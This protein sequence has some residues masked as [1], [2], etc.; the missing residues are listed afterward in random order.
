[1]ES[2]AEAQLLTCD[3]V[4]DA[5][6]SGFKTDKGGMADPLPKLVGV[7]RQGGFRYRGTLAKPTLLVLTSNLAEPDWPDELDAPT[8]RFVYYGDNRHPGLQLHDTQRFGNQLLIKLFDM[9]HSEERA[10]IPPVLIFTSEGPG[11]SYRFRGLAVPG[12]PTMPATEDLV[13][14]WKTAGNRRFQNYRAVF[15]ILDV[16]VL[17]RRWIESIKSGGNDMASAPSAWRSWIES[18]AIKPLEAP[19]TQLIRTKEEQLPSSESEQALLEVI[20]ARY[21]DNAFGFEACAGAIARLLLGDVTRLDLTRAWRDGGRDGI[22]TVRLGRG[23]ASIEVT[24]A[25]EAK[26]YGQ[27]NSVGVREASRLISRIKHREFGVLVTTSFINKQAYEEVVNDG[28][29]VIFVTAVDIV[30]L[31]RDVGY[32]TPPLVN[33]WLNS[34]ASSAH[35]DSIQKQSMEVS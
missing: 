11:R 32:S 16:P 14:I 23:P 28:H 6:Y 30:R 10:D 3:L 33:S 4:I 18:G 34:L 24:F 9:A 7:S 31:L 19:R 35:P 1:M 27:D 22:G 15:T 2:Q 8:G 26:C 20:R 25:L 12:H 17:S 5:I 13:A 29:P 21:K